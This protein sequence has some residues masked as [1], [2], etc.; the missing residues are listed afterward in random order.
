MLA[1]ALVGLAVTASARALRIMDLLAVTHIIIAQAARAARADDI[2]LSYIPIAK[3][4]II[5]FM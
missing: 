2:R 3:I 5:F 4:A 1:W